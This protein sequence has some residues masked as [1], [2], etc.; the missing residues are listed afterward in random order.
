MTPET[1][2][3]LLATLSHEVRSTWAALPECGAALSAV[4]LS[5]STGFSQARTRAHLA[6]LG[7][8]GL[9]HQQRLPLMADA[10]AATWARAQPREVLS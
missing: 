5:D 10:G 2:R 8:L 7:K 1:R 6:F 9:V 4:A 3:A